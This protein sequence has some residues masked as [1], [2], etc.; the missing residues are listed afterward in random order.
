MLLNVSTKA[1]MFVC[2]SMTAASKRENSKLIKRT[3]VWEKFFS[4]NAA[5]LCAPRRRPERVHG[6][7][8]CARSYE[9]ARIKYKFIHTYTR[10]RRCN[11]WVRATFKSPGD[12]TSRKKRRLLSTRA[13]ECRNI[14]YLTRRHRVR[15][16]ER[17]TVRASAHI[18]GN[19]SNR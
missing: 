12:G 8:A 9:R 6:L 13:C 19:R 11:G 4:R 17:K 1:N 15:G 5:H 7:Y 2:K 16:C 3:A 14:L 10:L 18:Y